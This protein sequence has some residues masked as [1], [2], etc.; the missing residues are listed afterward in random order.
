MEKT[1]K[2]PSRTREKPQLGKK[3]VLAD[4]AAEEF[5]ER[6]SASGIPRA[7]LAHA[8]FEQALVAAIPEGPVTIEKA[9][10]Y[11]G[12]LLYFQQRLETEIAEMEAIADPV[13]H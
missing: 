4:Q 3:R 2:Q 7:V 1:E 6:G 5:V 12:H 11:F 8:L 9:G 10:L 13:R